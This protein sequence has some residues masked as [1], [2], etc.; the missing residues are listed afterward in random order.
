[1]T[2][3]ELIN[4]YY[5]LSGEKVL[6]VLETVG[7]NAYCIS[8]LNQDGSKVSTLVEICL[9]GNGEYAVERDYCIPGREKGMISRYFGDDELD[10]D[11][12]IDDID[13]L[14]GELGD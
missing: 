3:L 6:E 9:G 7:G 14:L 5:D 12:D 1:M 11:A 10:E 13:D 2:H 4:E 8:I